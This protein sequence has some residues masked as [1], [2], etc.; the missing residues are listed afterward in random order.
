[1]RYQLS[2][3]VLELSQNIIL[4]LP[5]QGWR[6]SLASTVLRVQL[7]NESGAHGTSDK[8]KWEK[9]VGILY[10]SFG[11]IFGFGSGSTA[12]FDKTEC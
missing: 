6:I 1:M 5:T 9:I 3:R 2:R 12:Q 4:L 10:F 7:R 8:A 11:T